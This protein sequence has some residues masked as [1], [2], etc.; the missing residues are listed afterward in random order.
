M[1]PDLGPEGI[2]GRLIALRKALALLLSRLPPA[3]L[4]ALFAHEALLTGDEDP[5]AMADAV[6]AV[7]GAMAL[8]LAALRD[9]ADRQRAR[10]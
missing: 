7:A 4:A 1:R 9:E 6:A 5:A 8:E 2:E 3:D 10:A